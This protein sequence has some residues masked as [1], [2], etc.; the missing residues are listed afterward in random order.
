MRFRYLTR[1]LTA[2]AAIEIWLFTAFS[3]FIARNTHVYSAK[4]NDRE[5]RK[6]K[7]ENMA[8]NED[9]ELK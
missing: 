7:E 2:F 9:N 6:K 8:L 4:T 1:L 5:R 3:Y